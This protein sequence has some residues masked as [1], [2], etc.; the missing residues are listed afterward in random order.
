[1]VHFFIAERVAV[2]FRFRGVESS[3]LS[4]GLEM[5]DFRVETNRLTANKKGRSEG[6]GTPEPST[7]PSG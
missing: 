3:L 6:S 2:S 7:A 1:M 4:G 5:L